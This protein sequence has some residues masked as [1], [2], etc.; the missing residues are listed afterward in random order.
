MDI[1]FLGAGAVNKHIDYHAEL[2]KPTN[3]MQMQIVA[4]QGKKVLNRTTVRVL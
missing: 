2:D 4:K 3:S 1:V